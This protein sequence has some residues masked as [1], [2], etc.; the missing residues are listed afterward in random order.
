MEKVDDC[1][2]MTTIS[3]AARALGRRGGKAKSAAKS[4]ASRQ[5]GKLGGRPRRKPKPLEV[6]PGAHEPRRLL[7]LLDSHIAAQRELVFADEDSEIRGHPRI[8]D[9]PLARGSGRLWDKAGQRG[10]AR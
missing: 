5:N 1:T 10:G 4:N 8:G 9:R 3:D 7:A 6:F 2:P